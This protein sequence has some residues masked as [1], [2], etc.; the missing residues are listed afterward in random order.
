MSPKYQLYESSRPCVRASSTFSCIFAMTIILHVHVSG[1]N[2]SSGKRTGERLS[3]LSQP[4]LSGGGLKAL[5][6]ILLCVAALI[7]S[8][9]L[10]G[11]ERW[12]LHKADF[13]S[14]TNKTS[15]NLACFMLTFRLQKA[16]AWGCAANGLQ[17]VKGIFQI[18]KS[19]CD[20]Q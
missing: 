7:S 4:I 12:A 20:G 8:S 11:E 18:Q 14:N 3:A 2:W 5:E 9:S 10:T 19:P 6:Q 13:V 17:E 16:P 1:M 15:T